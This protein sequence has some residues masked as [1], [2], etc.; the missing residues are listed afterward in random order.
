M[1]RGVGGELTFNVVAASR[2]LQGPSPAPYLHAP[3]RKRLRKTRPRSRGRYARRRLHAAARRAQRCR[4]FASAGIAPAV[5]HCSATVLHC[6]PRRA[7]PPCRPPSRP[8]PDLRAPAASR[9]QTQRKLIAALVLA[10]VFMVV[11]V[12]AGVY[13]HSLAIITDAAHLLSDVS[14]FAISVFAAF[15][16]AKK[17]R[18]HF[19]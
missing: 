16:V 11:E 10:F 3:W 2:L 12:V 7:P 19:S 9:P 18:E 5:V 15:W 1:D 8:P 4:Q 6:H 17:S 13:A 14:G